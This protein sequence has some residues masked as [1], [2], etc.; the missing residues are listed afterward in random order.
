M[1]PRVDCTTSEMKRA[2]KTM[3]KHNHGYYG[4]RDTMN[5]TAMIAVPQ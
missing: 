3:T 1:L 5:N 4:N 2:K